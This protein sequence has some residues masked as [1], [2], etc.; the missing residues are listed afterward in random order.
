MEGYSK[1]LEVVCQPHNHSID[2]HVGVDGI[3]DVKVW[4]VK[5]D[6]NGETFVGRTACGR[7]AVYNERLLPTGELEKRIDIL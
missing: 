3:E 6:R 1:M 5:G 4:F 7:I 2:V